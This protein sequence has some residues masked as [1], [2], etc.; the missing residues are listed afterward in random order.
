M[1]SLG[2]WRARSMRTA[3]WCLLLALAGCASL[4]EVRPLATV[5]ADQ[6]AFE[7]TGGDL[8]ALRREAGLLCPAGGEVLRQTAREQRP[9]AMDSRMERWIQLSSAWIT[10]P[11]RQA[12]LVVLCNPVANRHLLTAAAAVPVDGAASA[13]GWSAAFIPP[14]APIGPVSVEW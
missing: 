7:L 5:R 14:S 11:E 9:Q 10:A 8:A 1:A 13:P 2:G 12:Q 3:S 6:S 4:L